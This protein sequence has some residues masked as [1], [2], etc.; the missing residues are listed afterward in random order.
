MT[1]RPY[2][3]IFI[4]AALLVA[5][6]A[7]AYVTLL[8]YDILL[9]PV[10]DVL[11]PFAI[12]FIF[13]FLLNPVVDW[14]ERHR[15]SRGWAVATVGLTFVIGF[16][17]IG[18]L[19][20]PQIIEQATQLAKNLPT[21]LNRSVDWINHTLASRRPL[22]ES[23]HLP[24]DLSRLAKHFS[25]QLESAA[26]GSLSFL[27]GLLAGAV[28]KLLWVIV[29]PLGTLWL[30]KDFKYITAK[31]LHL[32]PE[33]YRPSL[34]TL[35]SVISGV[36]GRYIRGM[37]A[38]AIVYSAVSCIWLTAVRLD[39]ALIIGSLSGPL[40]FLP[41]IGALVTIAAGAVAAI[42]SNH[43]AAYIIAVAAFM[44]IQ[45]FVV[46]DLLVTPRIVG[47]SVGL[48][49]VL[50]LFALTLG[51][52]FFGVIGMILAVP[53]LAAAQ[54]SLGQYYPRLLE[55]PLETGDHSDESK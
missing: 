32:A 54:A 6:A 16:V 49:P 31:A 8:V 43:S 34:E 2:P 39:Y 7:G 36:F 18:F 1:E 20:V 50:M 46:F 23:L 21:F 25:S 14:L 9:K 30:L 45:N 11:P 40:Y 42:A 19:L 10:L 53:L 28:S 22:L 13:A 47:R 48:H 4:A 24:T 52:R 51:A 38:V 3:R 41:Y 15:L 33:R 27:A 35:S 26:A 17:A 5:T 44:A 29:I 55:S 37:V 12:A